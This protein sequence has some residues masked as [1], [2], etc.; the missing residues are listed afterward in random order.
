MRRST[1]R[2]HAAIGR[3][4]SARWSSRA[5]AQESAHRKANSPST[6][7]SFHGISLVHTIGRDRA[8]VVEVF[9]RGDLGGMDFEL[10]NLR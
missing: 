2:A 4:S 7:I 10:G 5:R 9:P 3:V 1:R 8:E 6:S